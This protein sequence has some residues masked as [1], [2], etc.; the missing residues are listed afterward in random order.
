M[1]KFL[2]FAF[3]FLFAIKKPRFY[4]RGAAFAGC[5]RQHQAG[6][7][8]LRSTTSTRFVMFNVLDMRLL[9]FH[10]VKICNYLLRGSEKSHRG[11]TGFIS[12]KALVFEL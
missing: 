11:E 8:S 9:L 4:F 1:F 5:L 7:A 3:K 10:P 2:R 12:V 6:S